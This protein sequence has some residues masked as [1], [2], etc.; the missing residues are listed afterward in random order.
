MKVGDLVGWYAVDNDLSERFEIETG[1]IIELS[2]TGHNTLSAL[3][4]FEGG[5]MDWIST[6]TL[7][8]I[9]ESR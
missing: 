4:L 6:K 7:E 1:I 9:S 3:V 5:S 2:K 8:V